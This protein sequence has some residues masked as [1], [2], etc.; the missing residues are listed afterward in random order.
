MKYEATVTGGVATSVQSYATTTGLTI[1]SAKTYC[2]SLGANYDLLSNP[3]FMAIA[4]NAEQQDV[5]WTGG[6]VGSGCLFKGRTYE[7]NSCGTTG[8]DATHPKRILT[9]S[10]GSEIWDLTGN[11]REYVDWTL[12]GALSGISTTCS[13]SLM[14]LPSVSCADV[15]DNE[16]NTYNGT[17]DKIYGVGTFSIASGSVYVSRGGFKSIIG[18]YDAVVSGL[19]YFYSAN[20]SSSDQFTGFRCVF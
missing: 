14:D 12:G 10:N 5:N 11:K 15:A 4:R 19:F 17:Y 3:E 13:M 6:N 16:F 7:D 20:G 1:S 18:G 2:T 8:S 9:L